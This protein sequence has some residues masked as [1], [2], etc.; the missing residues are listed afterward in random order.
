MKAL[1]YRGIFRMDFPFEFSARECEALMKNIFDPDFFCKMNK[2][3]KENAGSWLGDCNS[4]L[5]PFSPLIDVQYLNKH[6]KVQTTSELVYEYFTN[7]KFF[8]LKPNF[9]FNPAWY[10]DTYAKGFCGSPFL[11][12]L[13]FGEDAGLNPC[14][15]FWTDFVKKTYVFS[16][17]YVLGSYFGMCNYVAVSPF[18]DPIF[19]LIENNDVFTKGA[20]PLQHYMEFGKKEGRDPHPLVDI[21]WCRKVTKDLSFTFDDFIKSRYV[22]H[23]FCHPRGC[24]DWSSLPQDEF[25]A[26]FSSN[27]TPSLTMANNL[28]HKKDPRFSLF[29]DLNEIEASGIEPS[30]PQETFSR[31]AKQLL[32]KFRGDNNSRSFK[33]SVVLPTKNRLS[34]LKNAIESVLNQTYDLFELIVVDDHSSDGTDKFIST[35]GDPRIKLVIN[36]GHGVSAAR[37]AGLDVATGDYVA[38]LDSD[39]QWTNCFLECMLSYCL[40]NKKLF[41]YSALRL[42]NSDGDVRFRFQ[43]NFCMEALRRSNYID[44]NVIFIN[45]L[46]FKDVRFDEN[47]SRCVDWEY[48]LR[49]A[50]NVTPCPVSIVGCNYFHESSRSDRITLKEDVLHCLKVEQSYRK[51]NA[52]E[53]TSGIVRDI[54]IIPVDSDSAS[55]AFRTIASLTTYSSPALSFQLVF[56]QS[57]DLKFQTALKALMAFRGAP[58]PIVSKI[59]LTTF[60]MI[61]LALSATSSFD[62]YRHVINPQGDFRQVLQIFDEILEDRS[63]LFVASAHEMS[64]N[65]VVFN[66]DER[67]WV[68][69]KSQCGKITADHLPMKGDL[70]NIPPG[71]LASIDAFF[72]RSTGFSFLLSRLVVSGHRVK[73]TRVEVEDVSPVPE[74]LFIELRR[75]NA[76]FCP[77]VP[78]VDSA[79]KASNVTEVS[80]LEDNVLRTQ[81]FLYPRSSPKFSFGI[82][83]PAPC[84]GCGWGDEYFALSI[85][86]AIRHLGI[87]ANVIYRNEWHSFDHCFEEAI[88]LR[89]IVQNRPCAGARNHIWIISHPDKVVVSELSQ[90]D[91]VFVASHM[92]FK[93]LRSQIRRNTFYLPQCSSFVPPRESTLSM[94]CRDYAL[95]VGDS[96]NVLRHPVNQ[97]VQTWDRLMLVGPNWKNLATNN[98]LP[99]TVPNSLLPELYWSYGAVLNQHWPMMSKNGFVSNR[100][101]DVACAGGRFITDHC[102]GLPQ[103]LLEFGVVWQ[104]EDIEKLFLSLARHSGSEYESRAIEFSK[105]NSFVARVQT[106]LESI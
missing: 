55:E 80:F 66:H 89:G 5:V 48:I 33:V 79:F 78:D 75:W 98:Y 69:S 14:S 41:A 101:F 10:I 4:S 74:G 43:P 50:E 8:H 86:D 65:T 6:I 61:D 93:F 34:Q 100:L 97:A 57:L 32:D 99:R 70:Y 71:F 56:C 26:L 22:D 36:T 28:I 47:L 72:C 106:I 95:F 76:L 17:R 46:A 92:F 23:Y 19:Y 3:T 20:I 102:E 13:M 49:L 105:S 30:Y 52:K 64:V 42:F 94:D 9:I 60:G 62:G 40:A 90:F 35:Y 53:V 7:S 96:K 91:T 27:L 38:F 1:N 25:I 51:I 37:N 87:S 68:F 12:Y 15:F 31:T 18:F 104:G 39:N 54:C 45:R 81:F 2:V 88:H 16:H 73:F 83:T 11:H 29:N 24:P 44:M 82:F 58:S 21:S 67:Q 103:E 77:L 59:P 84:K 63:P 85:V